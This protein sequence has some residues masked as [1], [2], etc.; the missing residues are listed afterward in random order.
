MPKKYVLSVDPGKATGMALFS[1]QT[2][3]EPVLEWS[4]EFQQ[5]EYAAP[6]RAVLADLEASEDLYIV[7]ERFTINAQTLRNSQS[8]YSLEQI[9]ILKQC[10]LDVGRKP[11][12]IF[13]QAPADAKAMFPNEALKFLEYWHR[14]GE[15]HALDAI[16]H[17]L[18]RLVKLGWKPIKL[19]NK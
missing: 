2:G 6:I 11:E 10:M 4:G 18:L 3:Q 7:C 8:P 16:R 12:D 1:L 13:F 15:G 14:G 17:G 5:D 9:G 19:L